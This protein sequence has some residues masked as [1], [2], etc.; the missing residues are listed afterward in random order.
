MDQRQMCR[1][2]V[3]TGA[4]GGLGRVFAE[5]L[6]Q[7]G[8]DIAIADLEDAQA[9]CD[10]IDV[11]GRRAW[12]ARVDL[13]EPEQVKKFA[14]DVLQRFGRADILINNAAYQPFIAFDELDSAAFRR[15]FAVNT[16]AAFLLA[17]AFA[18]SM[19]DRGWGRIVNL[20]SS[21]AW[22]P[23]PNFIGYI[24]SKMANVGLTRALAAE[25]GSDGITVNALAPGLTRTESAGHSVP[26]AVFEAV[27]RQQMIKRTAVP[28][29][30]VG[31]LSFLAS[32]DASFVTG[33]TLHV[34]GGAVV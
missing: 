22:S 13:A 28:Q 18:P 27:R 24:T 33:Q 20:A 32:D 29:D 31:M 4:A 10:A 6:A 15:I 3:V 26:A 23:P 30:L 7:D 16:E 9:T 21:S 12:A 34:D 2:A 14:S 17:Q 5:R 19:R 11:T 25:L 1:V 8:C